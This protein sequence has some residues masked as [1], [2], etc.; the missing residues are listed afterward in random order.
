M[1][2]VYLNLNSEQAY[3][4]TAK[5]NCTYLVFCPFRTLVL[6]NKMKSTS[7]LLDSIYTTILELQW[8]M[9]ILNPW[10][11]FTFCNFKYGG[12]YFH[13]ND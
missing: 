11:K 12:N 13:D 9:E 6:K 5:T 8:F 3:I 7:A 4:L 10:L 2:C 1:K